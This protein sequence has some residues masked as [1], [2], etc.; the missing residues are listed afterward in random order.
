MTLLSSVHY[1]SKSTAGE[2]TPAVVEDAARVLADPGLY[3]EA[4]ATNYQV[5]IDHFSYRVVRERLLPLLE[6]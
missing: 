3:A 1:A 2:V 6:R 5:G 4:V